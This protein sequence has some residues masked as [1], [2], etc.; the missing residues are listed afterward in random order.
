MQAAAQQQQAHQ[1]SQPAS[2]QASQPVNQPAGQSA[3]P[4]QSAAYAPAAAQGPSSSDPAKMLRIADSAAQ[5][6]A[7]YKAKLQEA[8]ASCDTLM[9]ESQI[10]LVLHFINTRLLN[11]TSAVAW[12]AVSSRHVVQDGKMTL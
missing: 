12:Q 2:Q 4:L 10:H 6:E 11:K 1:A 9:F 5:H 7:Y 3:Q 8:Q